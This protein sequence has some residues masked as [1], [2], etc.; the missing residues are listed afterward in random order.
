M[1]AALPGNPD[2]YSGVW[3]TVIFLM[4]FFSFS[5]SQL[6]R[7]LGLEVVI[8]SFTLTFFFLFFSLTCLYFLLWCYLLKPQVGNPGSC[9][10]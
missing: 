9:D 8:F 2:E 10:D 1:Q 7:R 3:S 5:F 6:L 4:L